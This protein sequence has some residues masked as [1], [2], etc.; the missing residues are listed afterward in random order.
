[1]PQLLLAS[2][3]QGKI[4]ELRLLFQGLPYELVTLNDL[5]INFRSPE[6]GASLEENARA[7]AQVYSSLSQLPT[8][9]EDSGLEVEAL[10]GEPGVH[11]ARFG[12][13]SSDRERIALLLR[14][15]EGVPWEKRKARF[16]CALALALSPK[17]VRLFV[18]ECRGIIALEH[19]GQG[20][21]GYDPVFYYPPLGRTFAELSLEEKSR[22]SHRSLAAAQCCAFL[23]RLSP[24]TAL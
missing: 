12:G 24:R 22:V 21:F 16:R 10:G 19:R 8:L 14:R 7:K 9:A 20:G 17:D 11:S 18:G 6:T 1:M 4:R 3:N 13:L 23:K 15:L 2:H 5:G